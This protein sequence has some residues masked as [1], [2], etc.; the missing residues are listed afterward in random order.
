MEFSIIIPAKNEEKNIGKC[1]DSIYGMDF[2]V[3][4][5]EVLVVDNG[6]SDRTVEIAKSRGATVFEKPGFT[7]SGLR[8][9]GG[10]QARG[11]ILAFLDAD[12]TVSADWLT[13]ASR[14]SANHEI[15]C[16]GGPP[17]VPQDATW[18]QKAWFKIRE[19]KDMVEEVQW[20][21]SMNMFVPR[22]IFASVGG[23]NEDLV[24]CEDYDLSLRLQPLGKII[25]DRRI[26][27]VHHGEAADLRHFFR[28][29]YWRA[30]SN[31]Q[32]I[33]SHGFRWSEIPSLVIPLIYCLLALFAVGYLLIGLTSTG[34]AYGPFAALL[35]VWQAP[36]A[37]LALWKS[38][39]S[40]S[41]RMASQLFVLL[42]IYFFARGLAVFRRR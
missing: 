32:G 42:N 29:E 1:L 8:N 25:A 26:V 13:E 3:E 24:T 20:L 4:G 6:S 5:F 16:F 9:F 15:S 34:S 11:Q 28:K 17:G 37:L 31:F 12:C 19:K 21:E 41:P 18:V 36:L 22:P 7:I 30:T 40:G 2:P 39:N 14:Y 23:F 33:K 35:I 27:A 38:R 10:S